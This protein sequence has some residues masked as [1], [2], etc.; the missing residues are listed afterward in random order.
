MKFRAEDA[1]I[2]FNMQ[3]NESDGTNIFLEV[4]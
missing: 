4:G 2:K 3:S 1:G